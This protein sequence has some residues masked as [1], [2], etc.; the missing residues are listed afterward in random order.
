MSSDKNIETLKQ[1]PIFGGL[2]SQTIHLILEKSQL[3]TKQAGDDFFYENDLADSMY[4]LTSGKVQVSRRRNNHVYPVSELHGTD[5]FG[6]MAMIDY[7]TR[8]A[9]VRA[10]S[11]CEAIEISLDV[12]SAIWEHD[13][14]E[15]AMLQMNLAREVSRRLREANDLLLAA[16]MAE[17]GN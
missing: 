11:D 13:V 4:V 12:I 17:G 2:T 6:E 15:F 8:S 16:R 10:M 1:M 14:R 3:V 9:D 7:R 5:C